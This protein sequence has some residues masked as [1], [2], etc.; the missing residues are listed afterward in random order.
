MRRAVYKPLGLLF[1]ALATAGVFLPG[2][3]TTTCT[4]R[5]SARTWLP[6]SAPP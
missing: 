1:V 6:Y 3:P 2:V 4:P 5:A